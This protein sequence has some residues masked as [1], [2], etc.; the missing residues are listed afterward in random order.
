MFDNFTLEPR[1]N[2]S[3]LPDTPCSIST[4]KVKNSNFYR[5]PTTAGTRS[6][7]IAG[8]QKPQY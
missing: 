7:D 5:K 6:C 8:V 2:T 1:K 4:N 3:T